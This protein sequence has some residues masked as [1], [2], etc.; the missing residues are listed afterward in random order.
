MLWLKYLMNCID[1]SD[2]WN[3]DMDMDTHETNNKHI[4]NTTESNGKIN[5]WSLTE[6]R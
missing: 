3:T 4:N 1:R 6:G 5:D 2:T